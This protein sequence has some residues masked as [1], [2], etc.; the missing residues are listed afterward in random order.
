MNTQHAIGGL[1][2][3]A[4]LAAGLGAQE[5]KLEA[6]YEPGKLEFQIQHARTGDLAVVVLGMDLSGSELPG[7]QIL[8]VDPA[9][10]TGFVVADGGPVGLK[11][12]LPEFERSFACYAQAVAVSGRLPLDEPDA[13]HLSAVQD[14]L[15]P[16][17]ATGA[18][19]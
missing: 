12:P 8:G 6:A 19:R 5:L 4:L 14:I 13:I 17:S 9:V 3:S 7:G 2:L 15:V 10:V 11:L 1:L 18:R 16:A